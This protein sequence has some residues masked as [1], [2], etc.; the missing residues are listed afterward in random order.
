M[1]M[2]LYD[3]N[4]VRI[5]SYDSLY[6]GWLRSRAD[7]GTKLKSFNAFQSGKALMR[8]WSRNK[9]EMFSEFQTFCSA[10]VEYADPRIVNDHVLVN[11]HNLGLLTNNTLDS[12]SA[13]QMTMQ[14]VRFLVRRSV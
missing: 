10:C 2:G 13:R 12:E 7:V 5:G 8:M 6:W 4:V 14:A 9:S 3:C 11:I 1:A